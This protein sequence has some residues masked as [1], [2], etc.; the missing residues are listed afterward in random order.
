MSL[1]ATLKRQGTVRNRRW[2]IKRNPDDS[3]REV[4]CIFN[5]HEYKKYK[6]SKPMIG[7]KK[8]IEILDY[9]KEKN[10]S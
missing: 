5:P 4:K 3:I 6:N 10:N 2:I 8:L 7:D 1:R 9:E